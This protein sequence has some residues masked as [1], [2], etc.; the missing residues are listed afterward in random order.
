MDHG[1]GTTLERPWQSFTLSR[2]ST[3]TGHVLLGP[4]VLTCVG[5]F[6]REVLSELAPARPL[7]HSLAKLMNAFDRRCSSPFCPQVTVPVLTRCSWVLAHETSA[8]ASE[9]SPVRILDA[10]PELDERTPAQ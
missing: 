5:R 3:L 8:V 9:E 6:A 1:A 10:L 2:G 4:S 7:S